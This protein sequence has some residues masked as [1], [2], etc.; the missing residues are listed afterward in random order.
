MVAR[1]CEVRVGVIAMRGGLFRRRTGRSVADSRGAGLRDRGCATV[2]RD[3]SLYEAMELR[4][5]A[6]LED[7]TR[8]YLD[9][10]AGG[11]DD[12][13]ELFRLICAGDDAAAERRYQSLVFPS[14]WWA[15]VTYAQAHYL[16]RLRRRDRLFALCRQQATLLQPPEPTHEPW[17]DIRGLADRLQNLIAGRGDRDHDAARLA[18]LLGHAY[19]A[20]DY[21]E[22]GNAAY[23][24]ALAIDSSVRV[25]WENPAPLEY[26]RQETYGSRV[27][28]LR[29]SPADPASE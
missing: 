21:H 19:L 15:D 16:L 26:V 1:R 6:N 12:T 17:Q 10:A 25:P 18:C 11:G 5:F 14:R 28:A 22:L 24:D 3:R 20:M 27:M 7:A 13:R 2:G 29:R 9:P 23:R 8:W 4:R